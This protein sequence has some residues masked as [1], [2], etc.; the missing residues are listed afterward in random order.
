MLCL[1]LVLPPLAAWSAEESPVWRSA[2]EPFYSPLSFAGA[3]G[4]ADGLAVE[5]LRAAAEAMGRRVV[6]EVRPWYEMREDLAAGA[7]DVLPLVG[8]TPEREPLFDFSV[9]YL[10]LRG[11]IVVRREDGR[12]RTEEDLRGRTVAVMRGDNA[13]EYALRQGLG[14]VTRTATF[15]EALSLLQQGEADAVLMQEL[16]AARLIDELDFSGLEVRARVTG[17]DQDFCFAVPEGEKDRLAML[18]EGLSRLI[19]D[20]TYT[21]IRSKWLGLHSDYRFVEQPL[22]LTDEERRWI[23]EHSAI[24]FFSLVDRLPYGGFDAEGRFTGIL[25]DYVDLIAA[26][27]GLSFEPVTAPDVRQ[28]LRTAGAEGPVL[29]AGEATDLE[30]G[31][32]FHADGV[33][34]HDHLVIVGGASQLLTE[35]LN[36]L[37]GRAVG[38][39]GGYGYAQELPRHHPR[40]DLVEVADLS[41][42]LQAVAEGR[43][44]A[45]LAPLKLVRSRQ[46]ELEAKGLRVVGT[47]PFFVDLILFL[48]QE[49]PLLGSIIQK[50]VRAT[51]AQEANRIDQDWARV[52][53]L[54][55][56]DYRQL[57]WLGGGLLL[58]LSATLIW[59]RRLHREVRLRVEAEERLRAER[60]FA[61][62][63]LDTAQAIILVLDT[64]GRIQRINHFM[65]EVSGYAEAEVRG[66][67]WFSA[68]LPADLRPE[69][70]GRFEQALGGSRVHGVVNPILT[71]DGGRREIAWYD[72]AI[73]DASGQVTGLLVAGHDITEQ[74]KVERAL[75]KA[76]KMEAIGLLTGGIAHDFNNLLG[77]ILGHLDLLGLQLGPDHAAQR[78]VRSISQAGERAATL[79]KQ[80]L[81]FS[82]EHP[83]RLEV[84]RIDRLVADME[85]LI[86]RSLT[87]AVEVEQHFAADLWPVRIDPGDFKDALLNLVLNA[88]D[89]MPE[90]GRLTL[91][92]VNHELD[93]AYCRLNPGAQVGEYVMLVVSDTGIGIPG[94]D[95]D[96][97]FEPF[98]TRKPHGQ[99]TGLGLAMVYGF[100]KRSGGSVQVYSEAGVGATFRLYLPRCDA[101]ASPQT[102]AP[103]QAH[104]A[105]LP[106]GCETILVVDDE[107]ELAQLAQGFLQG[108]GYRALSARNGADALEQLV[109]VPD[110]ALLF[111]DVVMPGGLNGYELAQQATA[112]RPELKVLLTSGYTKQAA[113][114]NGQARFNANLLSKPYQRAELARRVRRLLDQGPESSFAT[115]AEPGMAAPLA[116]SDAL[117]TGVAAMDADHRRLFDW[118]VA[119]RRAAAEGRDDACR[120]ALE[121]LWAFTQEHFAREEAVMAACGYGGLGNHRQVHNLMRKEMGKRR[122][123]MARGELSAAEW[124]AFLGEWWLEHITGMDRAYGAACAGKD[125]LIEQ[126]LGAAAG[127]G[128]ETKGDA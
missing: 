59:N 102:P 11:A 108:L 126:T 34:V 89:A 28:A 27:T 96:K 32:A 51:S 123:A 15:A 41:A 22:Y 66:K 60:D 82:R 103:A 37:E 81:G 26:K 47:T 67:D 53:Y 16:V 3:A 57:F 50:A 110:V 52:Q 24:P 46:R 107:P 48:P 8:R 75:R 76:Q 45:F 33:L 62:G 86:A 101:A 7:L 83:E 115:P 18:N 40:L 116:W 5:L 71:K 119:S 1:L 21:A 39:L 113:A 79:T 10:T 121:R 23:A 55:R 38:M 9:P 63:L 92:A 20:G 125:L 30:L 100:A 99:G 25:A 74:R 31:G 12:I 120:E 35:D 56:V 109:R 44:A 2:A 87:P 122:R 111:T 64:Q 58:L 127:P 118:L 84:V 105:P 106:R 69:I 73:E 80:L 43:F 112:L 91:E 49:A 128:P 54:E 61:D 117:C 98:F 72:K 77:I 14:A 19:V 85:A 104:E 88:R 36:S 90:G 97:V 95:Q 65:E 124:A 68:F 42:G 78:R 4:E 29:V 93:A 13:E 17:F 6:F 70:Q 114:R 94:K